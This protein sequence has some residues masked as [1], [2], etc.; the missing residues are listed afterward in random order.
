MQTIT[1][2]VHKIDVKYE[3]SVITSSTT[4]EY[5]DKVKVISLYKDETSN[6]VTQVVSIFD[7]KTS[8]VE[9]IQTERVS[10]TQTVATVDR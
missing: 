9:I 1:E 5:P 2:E 10:S 3:S 4:T 7:K 8:K 6:Q